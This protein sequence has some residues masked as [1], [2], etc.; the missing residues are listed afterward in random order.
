[1]LIG[2]PRP[3]SLHLE[4]GLPAVHGLEDLRGVESDTV[5]DRGHLV[6]SRE[7]DA[8]LVARAEER[9][10]HV[11]EAV[12]PAIA[13]RHG[14]LEREQV[15]ALRL[16][17]PDVGGAFVLVHLT[18]RPWRERHLPWAAG[19]QR[20]DDVLVGDEREGTEVVV[21]HLERGELGHRDLLGWCLERIGGSGARCARGA[22]HD[23]Q[24]MARERTCPRPSDHVRGSVV[25]DA[26]P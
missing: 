5:E 13:D 9:L 14:R 3:R 15:V 20:V 18:Q 10:V 17:V 12:G 16:V 21:G 19:A 6:T 24:R 23:A 11:Q 26:N 1:V 7:L 8:A 2:E 4:A 22:Q 25:T